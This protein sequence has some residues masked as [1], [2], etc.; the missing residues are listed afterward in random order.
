MLIRPKTGGVIAKPLIMIFLQEKKKALCLFLSG[1]RS[2]TAAIELG[3]YVANPSVSIKLI[4]DDL[5][6]LE[7]VIEQSQLVSEAAIKWLQLISAEV[8]TSDAPQV[9]LNS[10]HLIEQGNRKLRLFFNQSVF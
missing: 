3:F 8:I 9:K 10:T 6:S 2:R 5:L 7:K 1:V 4:R